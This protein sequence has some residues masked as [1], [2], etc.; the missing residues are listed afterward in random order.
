MANPM[1]G[2]KHDNANH[3]GYVFGD[4]HARRDKLTGPGWYVFGRNAEKYGKSAD[5]KGQGSY[6][7]LCGRPDTPMVRTRGYNRPV[8]PGWRTKA[9]AEA[10]ARAMTAHYGA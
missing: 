7:K 1:D 2:I 4:F 8:C 5:G 3:E 6:V 9:E 10:A